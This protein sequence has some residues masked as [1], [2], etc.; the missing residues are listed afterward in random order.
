MFASMRRQLLLL[1]L[2]EKSSLFL[3]PNWWW[4]C[5]CWSCFLFLSKSE[6]NPG[7]AAHYEGA[8]DGGDHA[9]EQRHGQTVAPVPA[10]STQIMD[11][12][13]RK[14]SPR[15]FS[16]TLLSEYLPL[17][18]RGML[19]VVVSQSPQGARHEGG[20]GGSQQ[21]GEEGQEVVS[22]GSVNL[23]GVY[24]EHSA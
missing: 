6:L 24:L 7:A 16:P 2:F 4:S 23:P 5:C 21:G 17:Q 11:I 14:Y 8:E 1:L 12:R 22:S 10:G 15:T 3:R 9:L 18:W 13:G 20:R 19:P